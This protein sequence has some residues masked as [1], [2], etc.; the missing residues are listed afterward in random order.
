MGGASSDHDSFCC[1]I[2]SGTP[3]P[4]RSVETYPDEWY[5]FFVRSHEHNNLTDFARGKGCCSV[6]SYNGGTLDR[7]FPRQY[8]VINFIHM[9]RNL[10]QSFIPGRCLFLAVLLGI[11]VSTSA[12]VELVAD[13]NPGR[14][15]SGQRWFDFHQSDGTRA[16]FAVDREELWTSD[17]TTAGTKALKRFNG[18]RHMLVVNGIA[19]FIAQTNNEGYELWRSNGTAGGTFMLKDIFPGRGNS[20]PDDLTVVNG[21]VYFSANNNANGRE[22][23]KSNGTPDGTVLVKDINPGNPGSVPDDLAAVGNRLFFKAV[24]PATGYE[25]WVSDGTIEGTRI[26]K[27]LNPGEASSYASKIT[28][29]NG[30]AFFVASA[31]GATGQLWKTDGTEGGTTLVKLLNG[32]SDAVIHYTI[33]VNGTLFFTSSESMHGN[34]LWRSD[35]S[36]EGTYMVKDLTPGTASTFG[37]WFEHF[38]SIGGKLFFTYESTWPHYN[39]AMSDGTAEGTKQITFFPEDPEVLVRYNPSL[40]EINGAVYFVGESQDEKSH[41]YKAD[42]NGNVSKVED[43][44]SPFP[45]AGIQVAKIGSLYHF[46]SDNSYWRSDG[47]S[48]GTW[49]LRSM[50]YPAGSEPMRL[51]DVDGTLFFH[52]RLTREIWKTNGTPG[53]TVK[54]ANANTIYATGAGGNLFFAS[55]QINTSPSYSLWRSDGTTGGTFQLSTFWGD[56]ARNFKWFNNRMYFAAPSEGYGSEL[57]VTDGTVAGTRMLHDI[58]PGASGSGP[59]N[60]TVVGDMMYF[61]ALTSGNGGELWKTNGEDGGTVMVKDIA[62]GSV[63]SSPDNLTNFKGKLYFFAYNPSVGRELWQSGGTD[64]STT[65]LKDIRTGDTDAFEPL[66]DLGQIQTTENW[67]I[68]SALNNENKRTLWRSNGT[69][70]GTSQFAVFERALYVPRL[71]AATNEEVFFFVQP[72]DYS[73][74]LWKTNGTGVTHLASFPDQRFEFD[75]NI[76][77]KDGVLYFTTKNRVQE[78]LSVYRSDGT[79]SGTYKIDFMGDPK[80]LAASGPYVY[81]TGITQK[82]GDELFTINESTSASSFDE[83]SVST[84]IAYEKEAVA[85]YPNPFA[86]SVLVRVAGKNEETFNLRVL[87]IAGQ[88]IEAVNLRCNDDHYLGN[89]WPG[90]MYVLQVRK[91]N[92]VITRK[93]LKSAE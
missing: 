88:T 87:S 26:V 51:T 15:P 23:W 89:T 35:G 63:S 30:W 9:I 80:R 11:T 18:I 44:I 29:V 39:I 85:T 6:E 13:I 62:P 74:E 54:I 72:S 28:D 82:E 40:S 84:P 50:G 31:P 46:A 3:F 47:T 32:G 20:N 91:G 52:T 27:D 78:N 56:A 49:R 21:V 66:R 76:A 10:Y 71:I 73:F 64:A 24:T 58:D 34:E 19:F 57:W 2:R 61:G 79:V 25:L 93:I 41:L 69:T 90:G 22:L 42:M 86:N 45:Y 77:M 59:G 81:L 8:V 5:V 1:P 12:Q 70:A 68:F 16:F 14:E 36:A 48:T 17:G 53:T 33:N 38:A 55:G 37:G 65:L 43:A 75:E 92:E 83:A 60:M 67:L 4:N 7:E